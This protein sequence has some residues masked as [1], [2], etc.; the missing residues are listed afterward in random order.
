MHNIELDQTAFGS[1]I[2]N[3]PAVVNKNG[4]KKFFVPSNIGDGNFDYLN[5]QTGLQCLMAD[6]KLKQDLYLN[7]KPLN[8]EFYI[9]RFDEFA[10]ANNLMF[11]IDNEYIWEYGQQRNSVLLT[12]SLFDF[13]FMAS[14]GTSAKSII[15]LLKKNWLSRYFN[16]NDITETLKKYLKLKTNN[17]NF[18]PF[19]IEYKT[20]FKEIME[21][22]KSVK[23]NSSDIEKRIMILVEKFIKELSY[24]LGTIKENDKIKISPDEVRR[25]MEAE[26]YLVRS[27]TS[28]APSIYSLSKIAAMST[29]TLKN[30]FKKMY[31]YTL[32]EYF[33]K[34]RMQ[35]AKVML[36]SGKYSIKEIGSQLGYCNLSNFTIAFKKEF[37]C[38]P[39]HFVINF[40]NNYSKKLSC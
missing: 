24:K 1:L 16:G 30:K 38:L 40:V 5:L 36:L 21:E 22:R 3:F 2:K 7:R 19:D 34:S 13:A 28:P 32:Y 23:V 11:K 15:V 20:L 6:F 35:R 10:I 25:L 4:T 9:L 18:S 33:Q 39:S 14:K 17:Y 37:N 27:S 8:E 12:S 31:G 26:S 29:T